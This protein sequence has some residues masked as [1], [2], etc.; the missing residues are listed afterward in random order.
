MRLAKNVLK[1]LLILSILL[2][3]FTSFADDDDGD[4]DTSDYA[5]GSDESSEPNSAPEPE[6]RPAP[7]PAPSRANS[8]PARNQNAAPSPRNSRLADYASNCPVP[9]LDAFKGL[10]N[11]VGTAISNAVSGNNNTDDR[12]G[13]VTKTDVAKI[14]S[15]FNVDLTGPV[16]SD[17][18]ADEWAEMLFFQELANR[19]HKQ[20]VC[21][22]KMLLT[23]Q[24][25]A[26]FSRYAARAEAGFNAIK[27]DLIDL[28]AYKNT[29]KKLK[30]DRQRDPMRMDRGMSGFNAQ[31][32]ATNDREM[33][34]VEHII[35]QLIMKVPL[36]YE[37][38]VSMAIRDMG[39]TG[40]F[41]QARLQ[42]AVAGSEVKYYKSVKYYEGKEIPAGEGKIS[43]C[44]GTE[45]KE[46]AGRTGQLHALAETLPQ[47][48]LRQVLTCHL[49]TEYVDGPKKLSQAETVAMI[50]SMA[51][52]E[53]L[54]W[55]GIRLAGDLFTAAEFAGSAAQAVGVV[56]AL[57][58]ARRTCFSDSYMISA[59]KN[60]CNETE[61]FT[62]ALQEPDYLQCSMN[63]AIAASSLA[64]GIRRFIAE[65][66]A[67]RAAGTLA[68]DVLT[69]PRGGASAAASA[70]V[71][72]AG[73]ARTT[74]S[75]AAAEG[76]APEIVV[77]A[78]PRKRL[79]ES[80]LRNLESDS[81]RDK[82]KLD[83]IIGR[84][85]GG[86]IHHANT[87]LN[88]ALERSNG[89][90]E[91]YIRAHN[92]TPSEARDIRKLVPQIRKEREAL[93]RARVNRDIE[94][95]E[96]SGSVTV[97]EVDCATVNALNDKPAFLPNAKCSVIKFTKAVEDYCACGSSNG[98]GAWAGPCANAA[99]DY[100]SA[101]QYSDTRALPTASAGNLRQCNRLR[102]EPG[103]IAIHGGINPTMSG[104]GGAAQIYIPKISHV[105]ERTSGL[106]EKLGV[107]REDIQARN[108]SVIAV[109]PISSSTEMGAIYS[110]GREC[111]QAPGGCS[112][113]NF[114]AIRN[115]YNRV[116]NGR[117][118]PDDE[119]AQFETWMDWLRGCRTLDAATGII[120][121]TR[122]SIPKCN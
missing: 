22:Y 114:A 1:S 105:N 18:H 38:E 95:M 91:A 87:A 75:V 12:C 49:N 86:D 55:K 84:T 27:T 13:V 54:A 102:I 2:T 89:D 73:E 117:G 23:A 32:N 47:G 21:R 111:R 81:L 20:S 60:N 90:V 24:E 50:A 52:G 45:Y 98:V 51:I 68:D 115:R 35:S 80:D 41:D 39:V 8:S 88:D 11:G 26:N 46:D 122:S 106:Y 65:R 104:H 64:P 116:V 6:E 112:P 59:A 85:A 31:E 33:E 96:S 101:G 76:E 120:S 16:Q 43:Y 83:S 74:A 48:R 119:K 58:E 4:N 62:K 71:A 78:S 100:L 97:D 3:C 72:A 79:T 19:S 14:D 61:D 29:I 28:I 118:L 30:E 107:V 56:A 57:N 44:L 5:V 99:A 110:L 92:F 25:S 66:R 53:G 63:V 70:E 108:V 9:I 109:S 34:E 15:L 37:P 113:A 10:T 121:Q 94:T 103:T 67:K 93:T 82:E 40:R 77:T 42:R 69:H 17:F 7:A 36:G